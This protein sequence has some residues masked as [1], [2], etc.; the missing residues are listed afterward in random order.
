MGSP[1][2]PAGVPPRSILKIMGRW[3]PGVGVEDLGE[4]PFVMVA[5]IH[6]AGAGPVHWGLDGA[7]P[8]GGGGGLAEE[9]TGLDRRRGR[10]GGRGEEQGGGER[11]G[12]HGAS[13]RLVRGLGSDMV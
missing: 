4:D 6:A 7:A 12:S 11:E 9:V 5:A 1:V 3:S 8:E 13:V 10:G 2:R